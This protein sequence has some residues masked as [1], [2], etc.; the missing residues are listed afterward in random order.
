MSMKYL[1]IIWLFLVC[2]A[3]NSGIDKESLE[4]TPSKIYFS[5]NGLVV[6]SVFDFGEA[7]IVYDLYINKSGYLDRGAN[8]V[9]SYDPSIL[10]E[11]GVDQETTK[12]FPSSVISFENERMEME[13]N[14]TLMKNS[15]IIN[16]NDVRTLLTQNPSISYVI[17]IRLTVSETNNVVVNN[18]KNSLLLELNLINPIVTLKNKGMLSEYF[19]N[20]FKNPETKELSLPI[21][22]SLPFENTVY[23]FAFTSLIDP[24]LVDA[25]NEK[26]G[27]NYEILPKGSYLIPEMKIR[28][29][30]D[31]INANIT[32]LINNLPISKGGSN[33]LLP[34]KVTNSGNPDI[35]IEEDAIVYYKIKQVSKWTGKWDNTIHSGETGLSTTSGTTHSTALYSRGDALEKFTESTIVNALAKIT[36]NDAIVCPGWNGTMFEQCSPIIK[37]TDEDAGDGKKKIE[38]L[39][40][41]AGG[42]V[43][44]GSNVVTNNKSTYDPI[45]NVIYLDYEGEYSWGA[46]HIKRSFSNQILSE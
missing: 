44:I 27:T 19:F 16:L 10:E 7:E 26:E 36:D 34:V 33:Y 5:K 24:T 9:L 13:E 40:T 2:V 28:A 18:Q 21:E 39:A 3:C 38:I 37:V 43:G 11:S 15:L 23:D 17:P 22:L 14:Q 41:W 30:E 45:K 4:Q 20:P 46:F 32:V 8:I 31:N 29:G 6:Q 1:S 25:F 12:P 42:A 35:A